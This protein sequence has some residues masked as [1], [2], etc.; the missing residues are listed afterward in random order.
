MKFL[1]ESANWRC[2]AI[3]RA[4][5]VASLGHDPA[6][7]ARPC[8]AQS[9]IAS[10]DGCIGFAGT[11]PL[12]PDISDLGQE[13]PFLLPSV[14]VATFLADLLVSEDAH[15]T[16]SSTCVG[17]P[18]TPYAP[19]ACVHAVGRAAARLHVG[20]GRQAA[21]ST[22]SEQAPCFKE[23]LGSAAHPCRG[24]AART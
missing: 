14:Q 3:S 24:C 7:R 16:S 5:L 12:V 8:R 15:V 4:E 13:Q 20:D 6:V 9:A 23:V 10:C 11:Q 19:G 22:S 18:A 2:N 17:G 21:A 1:H